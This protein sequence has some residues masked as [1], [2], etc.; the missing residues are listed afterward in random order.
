[1]AYLVK[2][3]CFAPRSFLCDLLLAVSWLAIASQAIAADRTW[4]DPTGGGYTSTSN[5]KD[6]FVALDG[7]FA[8]FGVSTLFNPQANYTVSLFTNVKIALLLVEDDLVTFD[9]NGH[10]YET[11]ATGS[12]M[13]I[14]TVASRTGSFTVT[15]G[16]FASPLN[17]H[18]EV[19]T[20]GNGG[21][22]TVTTGGLL[23]GTPVIHMGDGANGTLTIN[24]GGD[25]IASDVDL[26]F[27]PGNTGTAT[28][29]GA[30]SSLLAAALN[31]GK[32]GSG[33]L[34]ILASG[35][36][37]STSGTIANVAG[38]TGVVTVDGTNSQWNDSGDL[39]IGNAGT[40]TLNIQ[41]GGKVQSKNGFIGFDGGGGTVSVSGTNS[42]WINSGAVQVGLFGQ[43]SL[44][45]ADGG[46]VQ[47]VEG[48]IG[49]LN[50]NSTALVSGAGSA[51]NAGFFSVGFEGTGQL[52]IENGAS[53]SS[54]S[55]SIG[56]LSGSNGTA[57]VTVRRLNLVECRQSHRG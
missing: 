18:I 39:K 28:I 43:G 52:T 19:G 5:W 4:I 46:Y 10:L 50:Q 31:V 48:N 22:L 56:L 53:I 35:R 32:S 54:S 6:G 8:H 1:M 38:K 7:D 36:V 37:D 11:T 26:A 12:T 49:G 45:I 24:N 41:A 57:T 14:G 25:I 16:T 42:R 34:N 55:G 30:S 40:G 47:G 3:R 29:T 2:V 9:L 27:S 21:F 20:T 44:T 13:F 33:T 17:S 51:W 15:D 23:I